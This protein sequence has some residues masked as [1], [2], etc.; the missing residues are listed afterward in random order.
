MAKHEVK[1]GINYTM[2]SMIMINEYKNKVITGIITQQGI[3]NEQ[4][5]TRWDV[6]KE[7]LKFIDWDMKHFKDLAVL[8]PNRDLMNK[9]EIE[10][11]V[12][13]QAKN[14]WIN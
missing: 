5:Y 4:K 7:V 8:N 3:E 9:E 6:L 2:E 12:K 14:L 11:Y 10:R 1:G 13:E